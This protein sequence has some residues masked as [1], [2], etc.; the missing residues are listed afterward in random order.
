M[1]KLFSKGNK[2]SVT[3]KIFIHSKNK[4]PYCKKILDENSKTVFI[5][6]FDESI[7]ELESYF[8]QTSVQASI[9]KART[10]YRSQ[11]EGMRVV[12]IEHHPMKTK[13][14]QFF[15][16]LNLKN[17]VFLSAVDE[18]LLKYFGG[19]KLVKVMESLGMKEEDPIEHKLITQSIVTAQKKIDAKVLVEQS[20]KSQAEW[21]Q[22]NLK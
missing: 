9:L 12:F 14:D 5:G 17:V 7:D 22:R 6:W 10:A 16:Q 1:F 13:E 20:T 15:D 8:L 2:P 18:P 3:D 21:M 11:I 19:E 4:W